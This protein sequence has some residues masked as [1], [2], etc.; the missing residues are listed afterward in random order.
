MALA[1]IVEDHGTIGQGNRGWQ[2]MKAAF[3]APAD[4]VGLDI[5][6]A[7]GSPK[8]DPPDVCFHV[9]EGDVIEADFKVGGFGFAQAVKDGLAR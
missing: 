9:A 4:H 8:G 7:G 1:R 2:I 3:S 5:V 6:A